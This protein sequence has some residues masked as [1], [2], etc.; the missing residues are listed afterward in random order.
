MCQD[1]RMNHVP[2]AIAVGACLAPRCWQLLTGRRA[3]AQ[4]CSPRCRQAYRRARLKATNVG[5][6]AW[7]EARALAWRLE[8]RDFWRTPP[9]VYA[10][11]EREFGTF[12]LDAAASG[13]ED[14]L[15]PRWLTPKEDAL[16]TCWMQASG[17]QNPKVFLNPPYS[18]RAGREQGLIAWVQASMRARDSG[19]LVVQ[20]VPASFA[21][22]WGRLARKEAAERLEPDRRI[23]FVNPDPNKPSGGNSHESMIL[24]YRPGERGPSVVREWTW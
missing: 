17:V 18:K 6:A 24:V 9:E 2:D 22:S 8:T 5:S 4:T 21:T 23:S 7:V 16:Q 19:A 14:A 15:A 12:D 20:I 10:A 11:L 1:L 3:D 13:P